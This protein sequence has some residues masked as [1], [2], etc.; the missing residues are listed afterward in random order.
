[1]NWFGLEAGEILV[2][3]EYCKELPHKTESLCP[4]CKKSLDAIVFEEAG[5]VFIEKNCPEHGK[6]K[7]VYWEDAEFY[8]KA[9]KFGS[10]GKKIEN[11]NV[12]VFGEDGSNC[13]FDCGLCSNHKSHSALANIAVTNR[14]DLNCW[15][16]FYYA[17]E[18]DPVYEPSL[19]LIRKMLRNLRQEKPIAT[20]AIQITGGEPTLRKDLEEIVKIAREEGFEHVQ[21]NTTG[22]KLGL[23][24]RLAEKLRKAGV[25]TLYLSFDGVSKKTN[26]KNHWEIPFTLEECRKAELGV[27]LV[28]TV[29]KGVN[30][31]ELGEIINF[32]LNNLEVVRSVNFQPVS[33][34]G[35]MLKKER[36]KQRITI[37]GAIKKIEEQ[38]QGT[39]ARED[40]Y[41]IPTINPFTQFVEALTGKPQYDLSSHFAC[42][43]AT[44]LFLD[45][46]K[47]I[48]ITR[49]VDVEGLLEFLKEE[50]EE[51]KNGK[52]KAIVASKV[53]LKIGKFIDKSK[54]PKS[55]N[56]V[57]LL[58]DA[59][60]KHDYKALGKI[61]KKTLFIGMMHFMDPYNYDVERV[62]RCCIHYAM[63]DGR[64]TPFCTF[65]VLP[66]IYRDKVQRQYSVSWK[67]WERKTREKPNEKYKRNIKE[68]EQSEAYRKCYGSLKNFF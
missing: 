53:L 26:P 1:M 33:L 64:I 6:F 37:P 62:Q 39:I 15:Y 63:P 24:K 8:N 36:E 35:R 25:T 27:V 3:E 28:P 30:D 4:E 14:C 17:K 10:A 32:G 40:F 22:I 19:E 29:I 50:S 31:D 12:G 57:K 54:Q 51:L 65:N 11:P 34:V 56:L 2:L 38:T 42:G 16:C 21:L 66:E 23:E 59:L 43:A 60:V 20:N 7:E 52:H 68:L 13:P 44:Y 5:K 67:E 18:N 58:V 47:V 55:I 46:E 48:P 45:N 9:R 41:P 61:H 49:F